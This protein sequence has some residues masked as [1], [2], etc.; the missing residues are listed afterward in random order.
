M[1]AD[2][3]Q[4]PGLRTALVNE[5]MKKSAVCWLRLAG[6]DR[7]YAVWHVWRDGAAYVVSGGSEQPIPGIDAVD[8]ATVVARTKDSR[9]RML[10]WQADVRTVTADDPDWSEVVDVLM[11]ARLN[12][13]DADGTK[14]RWADESVI[15]RLTPT[16]ELVEGAASA[17]DGD[18]A[19]APLPTPATTRRGLPRVLHRRQTRHPDL[20]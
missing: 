16:G 10:A 18:L 2:E 9:Q 19:A 7:D 15:T 17:A 4:D 5:L 14:Q 1:G 12:L 6:H 8:T 3:E 20:R 11:A 13:V